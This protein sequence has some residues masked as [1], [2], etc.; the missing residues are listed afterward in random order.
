MFRKELVYCVFPKK[1]ALHAPWF[2]EQSFQVFKLLSGQPSGPRRGETH[3][4]SID[5]RMRQQILHCG[6]QNLFPV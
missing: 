2:S 4:L 3:F 6:L 5:N 1:I